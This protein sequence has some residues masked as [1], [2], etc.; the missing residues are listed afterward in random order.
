MGW[1]STSKKS[2]GLDPPPK[3]VYINR[4]ES[5]DFP[6]RCLLGADVFTSLQT[7]AKPDNYDDID[8]K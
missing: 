1:A 8:L 7:N 2:P 4:R 3:S 6:L 5:P